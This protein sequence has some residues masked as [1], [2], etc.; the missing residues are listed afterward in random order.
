[1][2]PP[3]TARARVNAERFQR[4]D[5]VVYTGNWSRD[6]SAPMLRHYGRFFVILDV[7]EPPWPG[8][9]ARVYDE[10]VMHAYYYVGDLQLIARAQEGNIK[11]P[12]T[13]P[14]CGY[15]D[16]WPKESVYELGTHWRPWDE[17]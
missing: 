10:E 9:I 12:P 16:I 1:M 11:L 17:E 7:E 14:A 15:G 4:G 6:E 8:A 5:L 3:K 13:S 2:Y